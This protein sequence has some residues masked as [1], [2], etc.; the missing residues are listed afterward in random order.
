MRQA[1]ITMA[2]VY[3]PE[4]AKATIGLYGR[5]ARV[6]PEIEWPVHAPYVAAINQLK[7][8]RGAVILAHNYMT[9]EIF[10]CVSDFMGDSAAARARGGQDGC[11]NHRPGRRSF[12]GRDGE[13]SFARK[14]GADPRCEGW[15]FACRFDY[16]R[17]CAA[18][19]TE[20]S[21]PSRR[22]L[23]EHVGR[24]ES[25]KR[26]LLHVVQRGRR[27]RSHRA[28]TRRRHRD[29]DPGRISGELCRQAD[30]R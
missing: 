26:H 11:Q 3:S 15:L 12:H 7:R 22:H 18:P 5:V 24:G 4:V 21:G 6:I 10:H 17:R 29:H 30:A 8:E 20:I 9:P 19:E 23:C 16:R 27:S 1:A 28:P 14:D 2:P 13:S 25:R